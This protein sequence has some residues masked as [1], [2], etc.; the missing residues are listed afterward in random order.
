MKTPFQTVSLIGVGLL[1]GSLGLALK[2]RGMATRIR[3]VG[4]RQSSI[5]TALEAGVIDE[6]TLSISEGVAGADLIV[7]CTPANNVPET[8]DAIRPLCAKG[9][10][11]TDVASTKAT[12][13]AHAKKAWSSPYH[14]VGSHPMA[15]SEKFGP[16]HANA[17]L[18]DGAVTFVE[19]CDDH[20]DGV[21]A[22]VVELWESVGS[23]VVTIDP[24]EHDEMVAR[25]SHVPHVLASILAQC[26]QDQE[27]A[28][29]F[30]GTGFRDTTRVAEGRPELWRDICLTNADAIV[31]GLKVV[32]GDLEHVIQAIESGDADALDNFFEQ[33]VQ[34]RRSLL[35]Q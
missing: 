8:L 1:G 23:R 10:V 2:E 17:S 16:E 15:G 26:V 34:A 7:I 11:V 32:R 6:G 3:G 24:S 27:S 19:T 13:C 22:R 20:E 33:G 5:G 29:P 14:F 35:D 9:A 18:Y 28:R 31:Q 21:Y 4:R 30:V 12:I 25:T